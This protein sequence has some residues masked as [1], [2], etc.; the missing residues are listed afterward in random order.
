M[1][2]MRGH[3]PLTVRLTNYTKQGKAFVHQLSTEPLR[4]PSGII[5]CFQATSLVLQPPGE[6]KWDVSA[7]PS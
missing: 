7:H 3:E 2:A 5:K 4:D 1:T 6:G